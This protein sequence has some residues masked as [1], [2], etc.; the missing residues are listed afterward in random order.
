MKKNIIFLLLTV[1]TF[2]L[3]GCSDDDND[4]GG[5]TGVDIAL[6]VESIAFDDTGGTQS[7][8]I[9][10]TREWAAY[11]TEDWLSVTPTSSTDRSATLTVTA[12]EN[13]DTVARTGNIVIKSGTERAYINVTQ[14]AAP[15]SE[16]NPTIEVPEGY[17]LVWND[18]FSGSELDT[19]NWT[20]EVQNAG[21]VN[22]ELQAYVKGNGVATVADGT[23]SITCKKVDGKVVS[24]RL[25]AK[26]AT[27]WK[28]G[29]FEAR[30]K[31]PTGKGT[32]PAFWMMPVNYDDATNPWP[33]CGEID[34]MEEVGYNANYVSSTI[35]CGK[36]NN[37]GTS[38][39]HTEM[40]LSGAQDDFHVY[41]CEWSEKY[42]RFY[43]DGKQ[44]LAYANDGTGKEAWP[45]DNAFY[46]ILNLAWGGSWGGLQ[47]VDESALPATM[48]VDYVRVFQAK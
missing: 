14:A 37:S 41:A 38:T 24:A 40:F 43:V 31:L 44:T 22:N 17:A 33:G 4:N 35:H 28:Y 15:K 18:E 46:V 34:I 7:A 32:W 9:D 21:W 23:L 42:L 48:Q 5:R 47:G 45:F 39:E 12:T 1:C 29:W 20:Y 16:E 26:K 10:I 25:Y 8:T 6:S 13:T 19:D 27:G 2:C 11:A 36:Y 3:A 30:I